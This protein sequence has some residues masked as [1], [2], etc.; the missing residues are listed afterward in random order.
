MTELDVRNS[1]STEIL[2]VYLL[3]KNPVTP[4]V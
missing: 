2:C 1:I 4:I 3:Q